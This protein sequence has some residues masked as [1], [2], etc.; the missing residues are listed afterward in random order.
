MLLHNMGIRSSRAFSE[1]RSTLKSIY[2]RVCRAKKL[3]DI[4]DSIEQKTAKVETKLPLLFN[5][6]CNALQVDKEESNV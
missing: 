6:L 4:M 5:Q 2:K 1:G 3:E